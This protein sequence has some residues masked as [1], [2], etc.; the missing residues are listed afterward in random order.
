MPTICKFRDPFPIR[1]K[2]ISN[3]MSQAVT[4]H[5][6]S[7]PVISAILAASSQDQPSS[8]K[9]ESAKLLNNDDDDTDSSSPVS[10]ETEIRLNNCRSTAERKLW[11]LVRTKLEPTI[12]TEN[13]T[14]TTRSQP[15][16]LSIEPPEYTPREMDDLDEFEKGVPPKASENIGYSHTGFTNYSYQHWP[17]QVYGFQARYNYNL[18]IKAKS[19]RP[20]DGHVPEDNAAADNSIYLPDCSLQSQSQGSFPSLSSFSSSSEGVYDTPTIEEH[21][22]RFQ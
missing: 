18:D 10:T 21:A 22:P 6:A 19:M 2:H 16:E 13:T 14:R 1:A 15:G 8:R 12:H 9:Q 7:F 5:A 11:D 4:I 17:P 20:V 3:I